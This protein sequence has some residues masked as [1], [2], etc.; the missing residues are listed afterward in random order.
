LLIPLRDYN[1]RHSFPVVTLA[2]VVVN[3]LVFVWQS[4]LPERAVEQLVLSA[5]AIPR[6]I[7]TLRDIGPAALVPLPLTV[8]TAMFLHGGLMHL[9]GNMWFLWLFG[10]NVEDLLGRVRFLI[11]Y[12]VTGTIGALAQVAL[13]PASPY[14]MIGASG[15]VAGVLGGY[16]LTFPHARIMSVVPIPFF[17]HATPVPAWV[18]LGVWFLG[19]FF[20]GRNSGVAWMAHVGGFL[21]GLG[22]VRLFT[23]SRRDHVVDNQ[24]DGY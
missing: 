22:L 16:I 21:G 20:I 14:P 7:T 12:L 1:P 4:T 19:Q 10:D 8:V 24:Y 13:M 6:E 23:P 3:A 17:W 5:G 9:A 2:L 15:A 11:F 18:F